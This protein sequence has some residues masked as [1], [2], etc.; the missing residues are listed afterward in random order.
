MR[1]TKFQVLQALKSFKPTEEQTKELQEAIMGSTGSSASMF[2]F[3]AMAE[4]A[5]ALADLNLEFLAEHVAE[6]L[7]EGN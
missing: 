2:D 7:N 1:V 6:E 5:E 3:K 4:K